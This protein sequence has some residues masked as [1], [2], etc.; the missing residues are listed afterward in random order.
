MKIY[1]C[2]I[3]FDE[4]MMFDLRL[5]ILNDYVDKFVVAESLY[6]H[7]GNRKKQN[8][9]IDDYPKFKDKIIYILVET[10]PDDLYETGPH[11]DDRV[12]RIKT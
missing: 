3:F 7:S 10:E 12:G 4:K 1:D 11:A 6:T 5:N 2:T 9:N 8:F